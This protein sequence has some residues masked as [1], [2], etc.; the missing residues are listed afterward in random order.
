[1]VTRSFNRAERV[2]GQVQKVLSDLILK[3]ISDPRLTQ[4]TIT[5]VTMSRDLRIAKVYYAAHGGAYGE[6]DLSA[7]F[8]SAKGFIKRELARELGL[9]YMPELKFFYDA[10]FDYGA[11]INRV[12][13]TIRTD[14]ERDYPTPEEQ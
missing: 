3:G 13:K 7:G 9:R 10:S 6:Q 2:S 4:A 14:D 5:G 8:A 11:H 1:M 12:L